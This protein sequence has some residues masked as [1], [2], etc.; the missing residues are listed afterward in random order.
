MPVLLSLERIGEAGLKASLRLLM[1]DLLASCGQWRFWLALGWNDIAKQ[2]RRSFLGPM[3]IS[4][5]TGIFVV[6]FGLIGAQLFKVEVESY[7]PYFA[8]GYITFGF[9]SSC[10]TEGCQAFMQAESYLKHAAAPKLSHV[11]RG[12]TRNLFTLGHNGLIICGVL[13]WS[14]G[15]FAVRLADLLAGLALSVFAAF[16]AMGIVGAVCARYRDV[17]MMVLSAMQVLFFL[18]PVMWRPEQLTERAKWLVYLNPFA[19]FLELIR[20][21]LVGARLP[22][23][24]YLQA[25]GVIA[26]LVAVFVP[27]LAWARG[28]I[29][30]WL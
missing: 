20:A 2:Y 27:L 17:P 11:F 30:Y 16:L 23:E 22:A 9:F 25:L 3:W 18:T 10:M 8:V 28:R 12:V 29:V 24:L 21:P 4:L 1:A 13:I 14:G 19:L 26:L 15:L 6:A 5:N 7:L